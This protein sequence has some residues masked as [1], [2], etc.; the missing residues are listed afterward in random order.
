M[1]LPPWL[2]LNVSFALHRTQEAQLMLTNPPDAFKGQSRSPN[3]AKFDMLGMVS[4]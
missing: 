2:H 3:M 1:K 4:Y